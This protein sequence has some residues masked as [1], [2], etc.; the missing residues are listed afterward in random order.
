MS[1][2]L[3]TWQD[4]AAH[5]ALTLDRATV[6]AR[7]T[8]ARAHAHAADAAAM[9]ADTRAALALST[10]AGAA[11]LADVAMGAAMAADRAQLAADGPL[12]LHLHTP[13]EHPDPATGTVLAVAA[14]VAADTG[15]PC[16]VG[17]LRADEYDPTGWQGC[18][19]LVTAT[20]AAVA[21]LLA[22]CVTVPARAAAVVL[23]ACDADAA[24]L[25]YGSAPAAGFHV[26]A[27]LPRVAAD[28]LPG[29]LTNPPKDPTA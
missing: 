9:A 22:R 10:T 20:P 3:L 21:A 23:A 14:R 8:T 28:W 1:A 5:V 17:V 13:A 12:R 11:T 18:A 16:A 19:D 25:P 24:A 27:V 7:Y 6:A 26:L 15:R 29:I 2:P 4:E